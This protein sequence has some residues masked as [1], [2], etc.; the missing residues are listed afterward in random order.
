MRSAVPTTTGARER[1]R[2]SVLVVQTPSPISV[3]SIKSAVS[4]VAYW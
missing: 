1:S 3:P 4:V 2:D